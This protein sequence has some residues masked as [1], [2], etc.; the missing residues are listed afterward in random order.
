METIQYKMNTKIGPLYLVATPK[1]LHGVYWHKE[2]G[3]HVEKLDPKRPADR[4][5][6]D[7][8][9]QLKEYFAGHRRE[10]NIALD[11]AG[12]PFQNR[13][14]QALSRIPYGRTVAYKDIARRINNPNA[15]RAVGTANGANPFCIIVPCHRVIAADGSIGGYGGGVSIKRRLLSMEQ[16]KQTLR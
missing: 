7:A 10:F 3:P 13:V 14:W 1:G 16:S 2:P 8:V 15:V 12:T 5:I 9:R 11:F 6:M 4:F